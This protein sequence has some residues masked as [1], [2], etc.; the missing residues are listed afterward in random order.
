MPGDSPRRR[1]LPF[2]VPLVLGAYSI[3]LL[4]GAAALVAWLGGDDE[5]ENDNGSTVPEQPAAGTEAGQQQGAAGKEVGQQALMKPPAAQESIGEAETKIRFLLAS[6]DCDAINELNPVSRQ[7]LLNT[8]ERCALLKRLDGLKVRGAE[9]YG[10]AGAVIDFATGK[11]TVSAVLIRDQ[12]GL[13]HVAFIDS[14]RGVPSVD[15]KLA[16]QFDGAADR[17]VKAL[18]KKDCD[19]V[20]DVAY[21]RYGRFA[22]SREHV[23]TYVEQNPIA[24]AFEAYP[25]AKINRLGGNEGYAFYGVSTPGAHYTIVLAH[26]TEKGAPPEAAPLPKGAAEYGFVD[27][28]VTN[29]RAEE[30]E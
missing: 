20:L 2:Q 29:T 26:E 21:R 24:N 5:S 23:C 6:D 22:G 10:D 28:Y 11:R 19:A 9:A 30:S 14:F 12:D 15:T 8:E 17:A 25:K 27:A 4:I 3:A 18:A 1:R 13:L 7:E 16:R